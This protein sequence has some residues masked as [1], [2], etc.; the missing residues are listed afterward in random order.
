MGRGPG[1]DQR[2]T[3]VQPPRTSRTLTGFTVLRL[4]PEA[5]FFEGQNALESLGFKKREKTEPF[6][7][8]GVEPLDQTAQ[9]G[10]L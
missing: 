5:N 6:G 4:A 3:A 8:W 1:A 2:A 7:L 9:R 10:E